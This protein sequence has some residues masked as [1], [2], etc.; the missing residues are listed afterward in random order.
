M[1]FTYKQKNNKVEEASPC[2]R[3]QL[4]IINFQSQITS[5]TKK[6]NPSLSEAAV[7]TVLPEAV[8]RTTSYPKILTSNAHEANQ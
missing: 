3:S 2:I 8:T 5:E 1:A 4:P 6:T 7:Q